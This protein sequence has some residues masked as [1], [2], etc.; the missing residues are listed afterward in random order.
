MPSCIT[1]VE[2]FFVLQKNICILRSG[3]SYSFLPFI[4]LGLLRLQVGKVGNW[5]RSLK[6]MVRSSHNWSRMVN[7][8]LADRSSSDRAKDI[9]KH[10]GICTNHFHEKPKKLWNFTTKSFFLYFYNLWALLIQ[11]PKSQVYLTW[12]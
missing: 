8:P 12:T 11:N 1:A 2:I 7:L 6:F 10:L 9:L 3:T 5:I 4:A